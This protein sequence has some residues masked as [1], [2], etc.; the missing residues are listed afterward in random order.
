M[1]RHSSSANPS[2]PS[3]NWRAG[4]RALLK[5]CLEEKKLLIGGSVALIVGVE[6]NLLVPELA[7]RALDLSGPLS[8]STH[9][10]R[11][12]G[13]TVGL[14]FLQSAAYYL[15]TY[16]MGVMAHRVVRRLRVSLYESLIRKQ[17]SFFDSHRTSDLVSRAV[18]DTLLIQEAIGT[19][20]SVTLRYLLQVGQGVL[21]MCWLSPRMTAILLAIIPVLIA[22]SVSLGRRL[23]RLSKQHQAL[24]GEASGLAEQS[25]SAIR[26]VKA[27]RAEPFSITSFRDSINRAYDTIVARTSLSAFFQSFV[28]FL[29]NTSLV[30][31]GLYGYTLASAGI[32]SWGNL[33]A[34]AMYGATVALSAAFVAGGFSDLMQSMGAVDRVLEFISP[35]D[36]EPSGA[37]LLPESK[38]LSLEFNEVSFSYPQRAETPV[39]RNISLSIE[40]GS[41]TALVGPSGAGKSTI[42]QLILGFYPPSS[43][44][45]TLGG[46]P[47][48]DINLESLRKKIAIVP[49]DPILIAGSIE[50]NLR[51]GNPTAT[52][53]QLAD[54]CQAVNLKEFI[55]SLP[56]K[57]RTA[58]GE[59][60][61]QLSG[62]QRQRLAIA[63]ALLTSPTLLILDEATASLDAHNEALLQ[64]TLNTLV[65]RCSLLVIAHRLATVQRATQILVIS[66]GTIVERGSHSALVA[67][68]GLYADVVQQQLIKE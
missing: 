25:F 1:R 26:T 41:F 34:F 39:L 21:L 64:N 53:A 48:A 66:D 28:T 14:F 16:L 17:V 65:G 31:I 42:T 56:Q 5:L 50:E 7:R 46:I 13:F 4:A 37:Q 51:F 33:V 40:P 23:R 63:R 68:G 12:I 32:I 49:Q 58:V 6:S 47:L 35:T 18:A 30:L 52:D 24:L 2:A 10:N 43:G 59:R 62:G 15:R 19:R 11:V 60:G 20:A 29:L 27:C 3:S 36:A 8:L 9:T 22:I 44:T 61:L 38:Q 45:I 57:E 67:Q 54:V 55:A